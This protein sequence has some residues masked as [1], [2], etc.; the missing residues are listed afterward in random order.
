VDAVVLLAT[1]RSAEG[2]PAA[3]LPWQDHTLLTRLEAQLAALGVPRTIVVTR[4]AWEADV[5]AAVASEVR[6]SPSLAA[7]LEL[8]ATLA[9]AG[10]DGGLVVMYGDMVTHGEALAGL[11]ADPRVATG[12]LAGGR[13]RPMVFR[14][15]A[16]RGRVI[17]AGSPYHS[18]HRPT[19]A[20]LGALK[21]SPADLPALA[22]VARTLVPLAADPPAGW[23]EELSRK[24]ESWRL[25]LSRAAA[26]DEEAA[27]FDDAEG[28]LEE[29][30]DE[31][32]AIV[33]SEEDEARLRH[34]LA[35]APDDAASLLLVGLVRHGT[36]LTGSYVRKL[37]G[38]ARCR[39]PPSPTPSATSRAST[40]TACCSTRPSRA[41]T[42][43]SRPSSSART[44]STSRAGRPTAASPRTR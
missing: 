28:T 5:R 39:P 37:F 3:L 12:I 38:R 31:P 11:L 35:A 4:P 24:E 32:T 14:I 41:A 16:R 30:P 10:G 13:G 9:D 15:R 17:S 23:L 34:R 7:D 20:F 33:L 36:M 40:R 21:V 26:T 27:D 44:R 42:A 19:A 6:S 18:V 29:E 43:S 25:G 2:G 1:T 8:I 22:G